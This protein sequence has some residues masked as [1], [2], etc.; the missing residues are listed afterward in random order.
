MDAVQIQGLVAQ[1]ERWIRNRD[2][3]HSVAATTMHGI[4]EAQHDSSCKEI[5]NVQDLVI[6]D[7]MPLV[8]LGRRRGHDLP[9]R[10]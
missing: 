4:V 7:G 3:S 6:P 5:L 9:R 2:G 1:M 10:V 8:W